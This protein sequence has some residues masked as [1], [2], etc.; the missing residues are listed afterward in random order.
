MIRCLNQKVTQGKKKA[1][2]G[3]KADFKHTVLFSNILKLLKNKTLQ[4]LLIE[5][6]SYKTLGKI[7]LIL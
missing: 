3:S 4:V 1:E 2:G 5:L 6:I 7:F